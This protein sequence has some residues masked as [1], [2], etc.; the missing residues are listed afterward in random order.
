MGNLGWS[1]LY[2]RQV[3]WSKSGTSFKAHFGRYLYWPNLL[4]HSALLTTYY[5]VISNSFTLPRIVALDSSP[6]CPICKAP[7]LIWNNSTVPCPSFLTSKK[8]IE[9]W[10]KRYY[11]YHVILGLFYQTW[12]PDFFLYLLHGNLRQ[13][14]Y[15][16]CY[17]CQ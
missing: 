14:G 13:H 16:R 15:Q 10:L 1:H 4:I 2:L 7:T 12:F 9:R 6:H 11:L 8:E 5:D 17:S 3:S